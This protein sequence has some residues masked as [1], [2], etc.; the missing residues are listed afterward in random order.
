[1]ARAS[2]SGNCEGLNRMCEAV[3]FL[4]QLLYMDCT[5]SQMAGWDVVIREWEI[6]DRELPTGVKAVVVATQ[7]AR[8]RVMK[9]V[10]LATEVANVSWVVLV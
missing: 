3:A 2:S 8:S 7:R 1:M 4:P 10:M 6:A 9:R 5:V